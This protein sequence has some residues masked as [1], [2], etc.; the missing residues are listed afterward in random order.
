MTLLQGTKKTTIIIAVL[1]LA[2]LAAI[3]LLSAVLIYGPLRFLTAATDIIRIVNCSA[4]EVGVFADGLEGGSDRN[5]YPFVSR[6][7]GGEISIGN[8]SRSESYPGKV[9]VFSDNGPPTLWPPT[10]QEYPLDWTDGRDVVEVRL[11]DDYSIP[12]YVWILTATFDTDD[13]VYGVTPLKK[14]IEANIRTSQIWSSERQGIRFSTFTIIDATKDS[15]ADTYRENFTCQN[16]KGIKSDI[17][18]VPGAV[19]IYYVN[20]VYSLPD[21]GVFCDEPGT[22]TYLIALGL[23]SSDHLLAHELGHGLL[24]PD[25]IDCFSTD[26]HDY[27]NNALARPFFDTTNVMHSAS[28]ERKTLTEGQTFRAVFNYESV[29]NI[30][31]N[32]R[33][34]L[35]TAPQFCGNTVSATDPDCPPVQKRLWADEGSVDDAGNV[36]IWPPDLSQASDGS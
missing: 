10:A 33:P 26:P 2:L 29:I 6:V 4:G 13:S 21:S 31:Y 30:L 20:T 1:S 7:T 9:I 32:A 17:G 19:N 27:C 18:F 22:S 3:L 34:G 16:A 23:Q 24:G 11:E 15:N 36:R 8:F 28:M 25:H 12:V 14:A 35:L 5:D